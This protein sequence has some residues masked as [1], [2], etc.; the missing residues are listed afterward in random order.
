[1][2]LICKCALTEF[3]KGTF[4]LLLDQG[5]MSRGEINPRH[6]VFDGRIHTR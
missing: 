2:D 1:M 5:F 4:C 3:C 6:E